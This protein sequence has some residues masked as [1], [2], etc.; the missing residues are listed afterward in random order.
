M[1]GH[2][3]QYLNEVLQCQ[4]QLTLSGMHIKLIVQHFN[5]G[6]SMQELVVVK[7]AE[8]A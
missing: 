2:H 8:N 6:H 1:S 7:E 3:D 5:T 4:N